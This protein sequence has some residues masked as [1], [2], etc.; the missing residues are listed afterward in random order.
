MGDSMTT[1]INAS[2]TSG[3]TFT[4][5]QSGALALQTLGTSALTIDTAGR[6]TTPAQP[7]FFGYRTS[8]NISAT[9]TVLHNVVVTNRGSCYNSST[10]IFTVPIAGLY[11]VIAGGH[12]ENSQPVSLTINQ[13][14][15]AVAEEYTNG[16]TYGSVTLAVIISCSVN[17]QIISQVATGTMWGGNRSGLRMSVKY[18]G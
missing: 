10:G 9:N 14:G 4:S 1:L 11:E 6:I 12:A 16:S 18:L 17:D 5:D 2:N 7:A 15:T 3:L 8:G 13:N